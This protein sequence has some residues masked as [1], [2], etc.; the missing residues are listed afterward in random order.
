M[1]TLEQNFPEYGKTATLRF[2]WR[3]FKKGTIIER[4]HTCCND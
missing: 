2:P 3:G 4:H 1:E